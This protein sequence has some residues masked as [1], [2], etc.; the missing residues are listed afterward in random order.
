MP[1]SIRG[2]LGVAEVVA[3]GDDVAGAWVAGGAVEVAFG[4]GVDWPAQEV[5]AAN[6]MHAS[7]ANRRRLTGQ[8]P[9]PMSA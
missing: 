8:A 6:V 7:E 2:G 9:R 5:A 1:A 3:V 4:C